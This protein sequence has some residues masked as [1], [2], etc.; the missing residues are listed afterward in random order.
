MIKHYCTECE[1]SSSEMMPTDK[2]GP[3]P[4]AGRDAVLMGIQ[5]EILECPCGALHNWD[6]LRREEGRNG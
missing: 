5:S 1:R 2:P 6:T 4:A 3:G